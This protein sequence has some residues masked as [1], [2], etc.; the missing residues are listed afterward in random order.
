MNASKQRWWPFLLGFGTIVL[1]ITGYAADLAQ[2][3]TLK[4]GIWVLAGLVSA[5]FLYKAG[6][7]VVL[8]WRTYRS[9]CAK[10]HQVRDC[11]ASSMGEQ[12][13]T[14]FLCATAQWVRQTGHSVCV[15]ALQSPSSIVLDVSQVPLRP[16]DNLYGLWFSIVDARGQPIGKGQVKHYSHEQA[17]L[18]LCLPATAPHAGDLAIPI[19]PPDTTDTERLLGQVLYILSE[20]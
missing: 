15:Q 4:N 11:V 9:L 6:E 14:V 18:E 7:W 13:T 12:S 8:H 1:L 16:E 19:E 5:A 20:A 10:L 17:Y 3:L 2:L